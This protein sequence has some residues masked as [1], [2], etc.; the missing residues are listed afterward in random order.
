M[1][2]IEEDSDEK[3]S[4]DS[5]FDADMK[6]AIRDAKINDVDSS[7][8]QVENFKTYSINEK[9]AMFENLRLKSKH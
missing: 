1:A 8:Y 4:S 6:K 2:K 9:V 7:V 5:S 3:S